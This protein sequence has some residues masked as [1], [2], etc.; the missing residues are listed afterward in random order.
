MISTHHC[1][2]IAVR[3]LLHEV[4]LHFRA[5]ALLCG[6]IYSEFLIRYENSFII[7]AAALL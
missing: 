6:G 4:G 1:D 2:L 7:A 5:P 3:V